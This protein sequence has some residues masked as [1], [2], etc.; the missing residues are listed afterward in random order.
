[1]DFT[2]PS[3][4]KSSWEAQYFAFCAVRSFGFANFDQYSPDSASYYLIAVDSYY[5]HK[6]YDEFVVD[7]MLVEILCSFHVGLDDD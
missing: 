7:L 6:Y 2:L 3:I 5:T 4:S 1:M